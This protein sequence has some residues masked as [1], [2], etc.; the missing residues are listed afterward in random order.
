MTQS[1]FSSHHF[2]QSL[3]SKDFIL[4][5]ASGFFF[6]FSF[7]SLILLPLHIKYLG[8]SE[9]TVGYLMG[10]AGLSTLFSTPFVGYLGDRTGKKFFVV[11]GLV[12]LSTT[13]FLLTT[14]DGIGYLYY[15]LRL[16]HGIAFS[17]F[18][19]SAGALIADIAP[20]HRRAQ[21][22]GLYGVFTLLN[23]ALAPYVGKH[24]IESFGFDW[25][26]TMVAICSL[27]PLV[28]V[29]KLKEE[30]KTLFEESTSNVKD[31]FQSLR[32]VQVWVPSLTLFLLG[33]VFI[34]T[35][36]FIPIFMRSIGINSYDLYFIS[37]VVATLFIRLF[38]GWIPDKFGKTIVTKPSLFLFSISV[39]MLSFAY[40]LKVFILSAL[41]FGIS[42]GFNYPAIYSIVIDNTDSESR[43]KAFALCS[44]SFTAGGM[45]G[46]F[47]AGILA[48][49]YGYK[50]MYLVI[51]VVAFA[52]F[53]LFST[54]MREENHG[55]Q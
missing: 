34:S 24:V 55:Q 29:I 42:H 19:V 45:I 27:F 43:S 26:F 35:L 53:A 2:S 15:V 20:S 39:L 37:Y 28:L 47:Y 1:I 3:F 18:F 40:D 8:G 9:S 21:A 17:L 6:F 54:L 44:M 33:S 51:A 49:K 23:Y 14:V 46:L 41:I 12:L 30:K 38:C 10:M 22:V 52:S 32:S 25:F 4:I 50:V 11:V 48:E 13:T 31:F 36:T 7:H 5:T 16:F